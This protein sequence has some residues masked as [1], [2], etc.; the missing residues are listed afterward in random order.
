MILQHKK[1]KA[2]V[3]LAASALGA[4]AAAPFSAGFWG[5]MVHHGFMAAM[6]GGLADWFA[7][8]ALFRKPLNISYRTEIIIR[9]RER[10]F[11]EL[12]DFIGGDLLS[13]AN[14]MRIVE[15]YDTSRMVVAYMEEND[16]INKTRN[17][18]NSAAADCLPKLDTAELAEKAA[19]IAAS[20]VDSLSSSR[21]LADVLEAALER[22]GADSVVD[23]LAGELRAFILDEEFK[24]MLAAA[25]DDMKREYEGEKSRRQIVSML[26]AV[27]SERL[28]EA[29][30]KKLIALISDFQSEGSEGKQKLYDWC[31]KKLFML[32]ESASVNL[33]LN[34][35]IKHNLKSWLNLAALLDEYK[36]KGIKEDT[37]FVGS[38]IYDKVQL[39]K[40]NPKVSRR[41]DDSLKRGVASFLRE[42]HKNIMGIVDEKLRAFSDERLIEFIET[43]VGDDLQM[44]RINGSLVG[45]L[46][47]MALFVINYLVEGAWL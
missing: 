3:V 25:I 43:R 31:R 1:Y 34:E 14:I 45:A 29:A 10:I 24:K 11:G 44:I 36:E 30:Q 46:V 18:L 8:T 15:K 6:V 39:L 21:L 9:S 28:A 33:R 16:G 42:Q 7:V 47:G 35:Y 13:P 12:I 38:L 20:S 41:V 4:I 23:F 5:G 26:L 2:N 17:F 19:E 32:R 40:E 27:S 37:D 22:G